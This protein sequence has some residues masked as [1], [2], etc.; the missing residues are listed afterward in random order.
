MPVNVDANVDVNANANVDADADLDADVDLEVGTCTE[1]GW[2]VGAEVD[3]TSLAT[4][5][6]ALPAWSGHMWWRQMAGTREQTPGVRI[7]ITNMMKGACPGGKGT[8][9]GGRADDAWKMAD[10]VM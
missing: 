9:S 2:T 3:R 4:K 1:S 6:E 7:G 10:D 8:G 5:M